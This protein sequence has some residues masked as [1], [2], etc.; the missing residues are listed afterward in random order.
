MAFVARVRPV[1]LLGLLAGPVAAATEYSNATL[2]PPEGRT[3]GHQPLRHVPGRTL[4]GL[5]IGGRVPHDREV[6]FVAGDPRM[7]IWNGPP[8]FGAGLPA[9]AWQPPERPATGSGELPEPG[10]DLSAR[11]RRA[12]RLNQAQRYHTQV[13]GLRLLEQYRSE[14]ALLG[15]CPVDGCESVRFVLEGRPLTPEGHCRQHVAEVIG[16]KRLEWALTGARR[17]LQDRVRRQA[18]A[19]RG[20]DRGS[21]FGT[22]RGPWEG[23]LPASSDPGERQ[24]R[25]RK[26]LLQPPR[27]G[28]FPRPGDLGPN[29]TLPR[30]A[31]PRDPAGFPYDTVDPTATAHDHPGASREDRTWAEERTGLSASLPL[32]YAGGLHPPMRPEPGAPSGWVARSLAAP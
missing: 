15:L 28:G 10:G 17:R 24:E 26:A 20:R 13:E 16:K 12:I 8:T 18:K 21:R 30:F 14:K 3:T 4:F 6:P 9:R 7:R 2:T 1:L 19:E 11:I 25:I 22:G 31:D 27:P 5:P 29:G 23:G 32:P